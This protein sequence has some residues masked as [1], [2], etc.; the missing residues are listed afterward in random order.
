MR[1]SFEEAREIV[2]EKGFKNRREY[3]KRAKS[4]KRP[5]NIPGAPAQVYKNNGWIDRPD[6]LGYER[7]WTI[8]WNARQI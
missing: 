7:I 3:E 6:F 5:K 4:G 2:R 1:L 8:W